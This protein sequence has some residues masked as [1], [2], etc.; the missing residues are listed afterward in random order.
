MEHQCAICLT[1]ETQDIVFLPCSHTFHDQCIGSWVNVKGRDSTCPTCRHPIFKD[2][3]L[4]ETTQPE[5]SVVKTAVQ[6]LLL[7]GAL[8]I[9]D[10]AMNRIESYMDNLT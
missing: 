1:N 10:H 2:T 4:I 7:K 8:F 3:L 5:Q 6:R 9:M